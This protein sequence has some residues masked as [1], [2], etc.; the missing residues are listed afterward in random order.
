MGP[1]TAGGLAVIMGPSKARKSC[2]TSRVSG[3]TPPWLAI[4][5]REPTV[6]TT[7]ILDSQYRALDC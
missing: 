4:K 5:S 2:K 7:A 3:L 1:D 6:R